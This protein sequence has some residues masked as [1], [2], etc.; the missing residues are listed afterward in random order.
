[1]YLI[2]DSSE[3][4]SVFSIQL[5]T[6]WRTIQAQK[7]IFKFFGEKKQQRFFD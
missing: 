3:F 5:Q 2:I 6:E 7:E 1:M 4:K